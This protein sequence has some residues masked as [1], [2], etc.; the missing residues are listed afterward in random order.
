MTDQSRDEDEIDRTVKPQYRMCR[1]YGHAWE[2]TTVKKDGILFLQGLICIRCKVERT[3]SINPRS[4]LSESRG[5]SYK[6]AEGYLFKGGGAL[7]PEERGQLRLFEVEQRFGPRRR[8][9]AS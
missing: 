5:Y 8:R 6:N 9:R 4:K 1:A 2:P 7:T 3:I